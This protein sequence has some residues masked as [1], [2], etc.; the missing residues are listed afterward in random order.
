MKDAMSA[1][2]VLRTFEVADTR[3]DSAENAIRKLICPKTGVRETEGEVPNPLLRTTVT[4]DKAENLMAVEVVLENFTANILIDAILAALNVTLD[5]VNAVLSLLGPGDA[6]SSAIDRG[7]SYP[8]ALPSSTR[9]GALERLGG[10]GSNLPVLMESETYHEDEDNS[11]EIRPAKPK[12]P[13]P[14][15]QAM[16]IRIVLTNPG[17]ILVENPKNFD[18]RIISNR[19][20]IGVSYLKRQEDHSLVESISVDAKGIESYVD[21]LGE[22]REGIQIVEPF[23]LGAHMKRRTEHD[24]LLTMDLA[25]NVEQIDGRVAYHDVMLGSSILSG[26]MEAVASVDMGGTSTEEDADAQ[27]LAPA[28][29]VEGAADELRPSDEVV[30]PGTTNTTLNKFLVDLAGVAVVF[31]N[32]YEG[33]DLPV[34]SLKVEDMHAQVEIIADSIRGDTRLV[35]QAHFFNPFVLHWEPL[36]EGWNLAVVIA[37]EEPEN[38][39][40]GVTIAGDKLSINLTEKFMETISRTYSL[41]FS[42]ESDISSQVRQKQLEASPYVFVNKSGFELN[43]DGGIEAVTV[44]DEEEK[45][46]EVSPV[47]T[48]VRSPRSQARHTAVTKYMREAGLVT[49]FFT[50]AVGEQRRP[51]HKLRTDTPGSKIFPLRP[52]HETGKTFAQAVV[53]EVFENE[54]CVTS[55]SRGLAFVCCLK[56]AGGMGWC[57]L[58]GLL[59]GDVDV[60]V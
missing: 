58:W 25:L 14:P 47:K 28:Y 3:P 23:A 56:R 33:Q 32:D 10:T 40:I 6:A 60:Q 8:P 11:L 16:S 53:E 7:D 29:D 21:M 30:H 49:I 22:D 51:L 54:R 41:L 26:L 45:P 39:G 2:V 36:V 59:I 50:G 5:N 55:C 46:L 38:T 44:A 27:A 52:T 15:A 42:S 37:N 24:K 57:T 43:V 35:L 34:L 13:A 12:P 48:M 9:S 1:K 19:C 20:N 31:V 17:L 4:E 18:S